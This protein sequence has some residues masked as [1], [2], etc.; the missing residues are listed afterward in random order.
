MKA[1][2]LALAA[3]VLGVVSCQ[4][5]PEGL[6]VNVG[7]DGVTTIS[8]VLPEDAISR[9]TAADET[10]SAWSGLENTKGENLRVILQ[11]FDENGNT[12]A[13]AT[14]RQEQM[15]E[16]GVLTAYFDVRL[17]PN[18]KYTF[19]AWAD[20]GE[21]YFDANDLKK[22]KI[23][24]GS[25]TAMNEYR[26]AFTATHT[27][28][29]FSSA[30]N[31][32]L[33]LTRPFAKLRVVTTDMAQLGHLGIAPAKATVFYNV[34][35]PNAFN[36]FAGTVG[37]T[38][39]TKSF[40]TF[41]IAEYNKDAEGTK[42]L[43]TD[44]VFVP[45]DGVV[46]FNLDTKEED[47]R[48]IKLNQFTTDIPVK[49]NNL[50]TIAGNILTEGSNITV[51]VD[52]VFENAGSSNPDYD[53]A[54]ISSEAE[55]FAA[56]NGNGGQY[57]LISDIDVDGVYAS[58]NAATRT[59]TNKIVNIN[60]NGKTITVDNDD[61][62]ALISLADGAA[63]IF[64]GEGTI[65][66]S[67]KLAEEGANV[68]VTDAVAVD[69]DVT[70]VKTGL[71]ALVYICENGG[72]FN[73]T[74]NLEAT[75]VIYIK[76]TKPVVINGN[77]K[78]IT[79][80]ASR[81]FRII[82]KANVT[83]NNLNIV[84]TTALGSYDS[85][86]GISMDGAI[87]DIVL[88]L[89]NC[90]VDFTANT[91]H[92]C[93]YA[94]NKVGDTSKNVQITING[95]TYEG[96]NVVN[97]WGDENIITINGAALNSLYKANE[98]YYGCCVRLE[99]RG[100]IVNIDN[101]TF[102][103]THAVVVDEKTP[104]TNT[105]NYGEN[106]NTVNLKRYCFKAG[107]ELYY[108]LKDAVAATTEGEIKVLA[109]VEMTEEV[110]IAAGKK[111]TLDL[112]GC[113]VSGIDQSTGSFGLITNKGNLTITGNGKMTLKAENNREWNAYSSVISNTVG[114]KLVVENGTIEHLGGTDMAYGIDNLTN[115][116]GTYAETVINGGT[117]KSTY[118][119]VRMFL[120]G[121]EAQNLLTVNGGTIEGANKSI[122]MQD[123]SKNANTG[124]LVVNEGAIL[125]GDV[126]LFVCA[127]STTWPVEVSIAAS[128]VK[129]EVLTGNVPAGYEVV[130]KDGVWT[131]VA[132]T[133]V[134]NVDELTAALKDCKPIILGADITVIEKWD[135]R[136]TGAKTSKPITIDGNGHTLKFACEVSDGFNYQAAFRFEAA[137]VVKNLTID[138]SDVTGTG[139]WLRAIST[140]G[141]I[142]VDNCTFIGNTNYTSGRGIAYGEG[143]G[144][145][146]T[147]IV[148]SVKNSTFTN[149]TRR[150]LTDNE[151]GQD[152]KN[153]TVHNNT[154]NNADVYV[155][156]HDS[157]VFT[158][159]TMTNSAAN[160]RTY[161]NATDATVVATGN[162]LDADNDNN[163][164]RG[165]VAA[166][167]E[168]QEGFSI[169]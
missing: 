157:I 140:K 84:S 126:Y 100:N 74:K 2:I 99:G 96:A 58:T 80:S 106:N 72:E 112:N 6:D 155:S 22:V 95:G 34:E 142:T 130:E 8:V 145:A 21:A 169:L 24:E 115:G 16:E 57:I 53:Y 164:I 119:A 59:S 109:S 151:N 141:D 88:T 93:S 156:A 137:A 45:A 17:V 18:R 43:F 86:R 29:S 158:G 38:T 81:V 161:S 9:A 70:G 69:S 90:S 19:V 146:A 152:A 123:P 64:S 65:T 68:V 71:E 116:K 1:R 97:I 132:Y 48:S 23:V 136:Y 128:A 46:K 166:N 82:A 20:Q 31:I 15:L 92:D 60:L 76:T 144:A 148:V 41:D 129:G 77:N 4:T 154:F 107:S 121:I 5:E 33:N 7:G 61:T 63:L 75:E 50:T 111:I 159:N 47:G 13:S 3:L 163:V 83:I 79:S 54:T 42:T 150:G 118:R 87:D 98:L 162:T 36:A 30:S 66:G 135:N 147:D 32:T 143:A 153:V 89:N 124:T 94:I 37:T 28:A 62:D 40:T 127:G 133:K 55:F 12:N 134:N 27:E 35:L 78:T 44:Y 39:E 85:V 67:G 167:V 51:T 113:T 10:N 49:R 101:A 108:T 26:D 149:W 120:N 131:V 14:L 104:G 102:T 122:W 56:V 105:V 168:S 91:A 117:I 52:P 103:G 25:W 110:T 138:M 165:F 114:G 73:F 11:V 160:F 125:N 139:T